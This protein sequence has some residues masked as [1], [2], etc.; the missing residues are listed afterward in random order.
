MK[1]VL[2]IIFFILFCNISSAADKYEGTGELKLG[3][4]DINIFMDYIKPPA[5]QVPMAFLVL[6][7]NGKAIWS[8]YWYCPEGNCQTLNKSQAS[9]MC[10]QDAEK[11]YERTITEECKIF[12]TKRTIVWKNGINIG[13][14]K[15]SRVKSRWKKN[16]VTAKLEELGFLGNS[17]SSIDTTKPK[18]TKKK[19]ENK[20]SD[21]IVSQINSLKKL[22]DDGVISKEEF[23]KAKK[24]ILN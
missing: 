16:E 24:K 23:K 11:F 7:E 9:I 18:I 19:K 13:K 15:V 1:N 22:L 8:T 10:T 14:G 5:G 4:P 12:A 20:K 2:R 21:D 17:T 6:S 3:D